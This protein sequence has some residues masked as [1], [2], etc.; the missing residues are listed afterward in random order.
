MLVD[1]VRERWQ[2]QTDPGCLAAAV[3]VEWIVDVLS[4]RILPRLQL[5]M[6]FA[7]S[8]DLPRVLRL[9]L[10]GVVDGD[11]PEDVGGRVLVHDQDK[12][13]Q[14]DVLLVVEHRG[15]EGLR[16]KDGQVLGSF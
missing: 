14:D 8:A 1:T 15:L 13:V 10:D 2:R 6:E 12:I 9:L 4:V 16:Q 5:G 3:S 7:Q 11:L